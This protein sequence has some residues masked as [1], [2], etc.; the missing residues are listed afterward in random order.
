MEGFLP[1]RAAWLDNFTGNR[2][3]RFVHHFYYLMNMRIFSRKAMLIME[4]WGK[5]KAT[6]PYFRMASGLWAILDSNQ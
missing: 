1:C 2:L 3:E 4:E 6:K 5:G